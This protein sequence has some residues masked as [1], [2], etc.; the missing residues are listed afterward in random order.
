MAQKT[1][2]PVGC[3]FSTT[4]YGDP[5]L[6]VRWSMAGEPQIEVTLDES[7]QMSLAVSVEL[8]L[9]Y[10]QPSVFGATP[11]DEPVSAD[12]SGSASYDGKTSTVTYE[13]ANS[14]GATN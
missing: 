4:S 9:T 6:N 2:A 14:T 1:L 7:G 13:F 10:V 5:P 8:R 3:P 12:L 11:N